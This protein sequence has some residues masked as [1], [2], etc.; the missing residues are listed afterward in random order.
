MNE[1]L[2]YNFNQEIVTVS[3]LE[4]E[5]W[6]YYNEIIKE[7][8]VFKNEGL[9][10]V[11]ELKYL[12]NVDYIYKRQPEEMIKASLQEDVLSC[13]YVAKENLEIK[14]EYK[15]IS[16]KTGIYTL[17]GDRAKEIVKEDLEN[18]VES[19]TK[20]IDFIFNNNFGLEEEETFVGQ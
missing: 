1:Y 12:E 20:E 7:M 18:R 11:Y 2:K 14:V 5:V 19:D 3:S 10:G 8:F 9:T 4:D 13:I 17:W 15:W 16:G 6:D